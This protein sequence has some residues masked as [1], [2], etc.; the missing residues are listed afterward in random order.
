MAFWLHVSGPPQIA[1]EFEVARTEG[2][3]EG[4]PKFCVLKHELI[5]LAV[6]FTE[7]MERWIRD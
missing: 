3:R 4:S 6:N 2:L 5:F 1:K 7:E